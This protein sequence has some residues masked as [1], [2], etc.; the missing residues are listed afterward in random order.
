MFLRNYH[1]VK[2][3]SNSFLGSN[4]K[5]IKFPFHFF[6][7]SPQDS[8]NMVVFLKKYILLSNFVFASDKPKYSDFRYNFA[9]TADALFWSNCW[10]QCF[11]PNLQGGEFCGVSRA[12]CC[13]L[14]TTETYSNFFV[15]PPR[16]YS[17]TFLLN[18][19]FA[20]DSGWFNDVT[21][22]TLKNFFPSS[23]K[24]SRW[25]YNWEEN[26]RKVF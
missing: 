7:N 6:S 20:T 18:P 19:F 8:S 13:L 14:S 24:V 2:S 5:R 25:N 1:L 12:S 3:F 15:I 26:F 10:I 4:S 17:C 11:L 21:Q 16:K 9:R 23:E 22:C